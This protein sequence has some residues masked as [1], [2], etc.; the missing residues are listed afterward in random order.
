MSPKLTRE[1]RMTISVL[2]QKGQPT[3]R[4]AQALGVS[5]AAIRDNLR[6]QGQPDGRKNKPRKADA[7]ADAIAHWLATRPAEPDSD[8]ARPANVGGREL[9]LSASMGVSVHP[10][11]SSQQPAELLKA[12]DQA[13]FDAKRS[14]GNQ[15]RLASPG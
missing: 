7:L 11:G 1:E 13:M 3:T 12:A 6:R 8:P 15:L 14:G 9:E 2:H 4:I 10:R 5:E